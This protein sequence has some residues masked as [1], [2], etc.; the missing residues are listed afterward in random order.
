MHNLNY[1]MLLEAREGVYDF[2]RLP[3][4]TSLSS[5]SDY[6]LTCPL[7]SHLDQYGGIPDLSSTN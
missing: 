1:K 4:Q 2:C 6:V 5:V 3:D 7:Q